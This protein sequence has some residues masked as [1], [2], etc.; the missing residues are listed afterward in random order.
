MRR[1]HGIRFNPILSASIISGFKLGPAILIDIPNSALIITLKTQNALL[2]H[3][4]IPALEQVSMIK[5]GH[6]NNSMHIHGMFY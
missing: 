1:V 5:V 6:L 2:Y 3:I 4:H